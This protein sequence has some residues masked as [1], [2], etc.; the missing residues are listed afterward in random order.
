MKLVGSLGS[1]VITNFE[2]KYRSINKSITSNNID[3]RRYD[4]I[5]KLIKRIKY[6]IKTFIK[7]EKFFRK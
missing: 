5:L 1:L 6:A 7:Y 4:F 2:S 3:R